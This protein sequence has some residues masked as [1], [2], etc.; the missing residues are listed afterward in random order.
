MKLPLASRP[1]I[2]L[3][4]FVDS[5]EVGGSELNAIRTLE[6]ID[7]SR[8]ELTVYHLGSRGPLRQ[9][10]AE[11]GVPLH[12]ISL[13]SFKHP[14]ALLAG[15]RLARSLRQRSIQ[16]LHS[17]DIYSNIFSVPWARMAGIPVVIASKRWQHAVP[18]R[19][20]V[21]ANRLVS[22]L[23]TRVLANSEAVARSLREEDRV[24]DSRIQVIPNFVGPE[25]FEEYPPEAH[26]RL[27]AELGIP[28]GAV[29]IGT[30]ARLSP[31][32]DHATLLRAVESLCA[33]QP[34]LHVLLIGNGP[35]E[36]PLRAQA[37]AGGIA[38]RVHFAGLLPNTPNPHRLL[39]ISVLCSRTEGFP[40]TIVEAMAAARPVVATAVG[41]TPEAVEAGRTGLL[42]PP[43]DVP[44]LTEALRSLIESAS[45]RRELGSAGQLRAR[46]LYSRDAVLER[47]SS[48]YVA[49]LN[50]S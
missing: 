43:G 45:R 14:S 31:A 41:G 6:A 3:A 35:T 13:R 4:F 16:I 27:F 42:V 9:R 1:K 30:V 8:F 18:S 48:W 32:K 15:V 10:Y 37:R 28:A 33:A 12:H 38:D 7:R 50:G 49:V 2:R 40:N 20:H 11:L 21:A 23:A 19:L 47:L 24:P 26:R 17:Q 34:S 39:D 25:A 44:A 29:V 5:M 36:N 46:T 22:R